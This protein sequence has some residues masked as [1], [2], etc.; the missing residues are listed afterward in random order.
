MQSA[1]MHAALVE[2]VEREF[3]RSPRAYKFKLALLASVGLLV[4]GGSALLALAISVGLV[5]ALYLVSPI[6][7]LKLVKVIWIP[8]AFGWMVL[9]ALWIRFDPPD[10]Y[11]LAPGEAP[12]LVAEVERLRLATGAPKLSGIVIDSE[13]NAAA[14]SVPRASGLFGHQHYL[15]LGLPLMQAL[16]LDEMAAV[17]AHEFGHFGGGHSRFAGWIYQVR[18]SWYRVLAALSESSAW[19]SRTF[20]SFFNW[21]AP[22]FNAYSFALARAQEYQADADAAG[23]IGAQATGRALMRVQ[24]ASDRLQQ[25]FWPDLRKRTMLQPQPPTALFHEMTQQLRGSSDQD[26]TR[27]QLALAAT[28]NYEDT[29]PTLAQRLTALGIQMSA[30]DGPMHRSAAEALLGDLASHLEDRFS[31]EWR[32]AVEDGWT[33]NHVRH[34]EDSARLEELEQLAERTP[35]QDAERAR[36]AEDLRPDVDPLPLYRHASERAPEDPYTRFRLGQLLLDRGDAA[37]V[38]HVRAAMQ[39]DPGAVEPGSQVLAWYFASVGD[40]HGE[41]EAAEA[42]ER[43]HLQHRRSA[44][45]RGRVGASDRYLS[46][47]LEDVAVA[48]LRGQLAGLSNVRRAWVVRKDL[49]EDANE[50]PHYVILL[51]WRGMV[52][53]EQSRLQHVV[54]ALELPGSF[55]VITAPNQRR[56][57]RRVKKVA[58]AP[59]YER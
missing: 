5:V 45:E 11:R 2:R 23:V 33:Q 20:T 37:G 18:V 16:D 4:L 9:R 34:V 58:G 6:L 41:I 3:Q 32:Q 56:V 19:M 28:G 12:E 50:P 24:L 57:A 26:D 17:I 22:Y 15:V 52:L 48:A 31:E 42:L 49:G 14:A 1:Q 7:L 51:Q 8:V 40:T 53:S 39:L 36:L 35:M 30:L 27:L 13:L 29:H 46:H 25:D 21:Y 54:D 59:T 47:G 38:E 44:A 43:C 10:G 55:I